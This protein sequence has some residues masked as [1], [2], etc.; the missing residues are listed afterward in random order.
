MQEYYFRSDCET[1]TLLLVSFACFY[2][3]NEKSILESN[4]SLIF[5]IFVVVVVEDICDLSYNTP[6]KQNFGTRLGFA[7][8]TLAGYAK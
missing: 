8:R 1:R 3:K 4:V 2:R 6:E 5:F 7:M